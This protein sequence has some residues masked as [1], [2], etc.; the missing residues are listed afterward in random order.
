MSTALRQSDAE[1][2]RERD[3]DDERGKD[4]EREG[5]QEPWPPPARA[6]RRARTAAAL[7][8]LISE[9]LA[10]AASTVPRPSTRVRLAPERYARQSN[11]GG[12][13]EGTGRRGRRRAGVLFSPPRERV[14]VASIAVRPARPRVE[15][16][17]IVPFLAVPFGERDRGRLS[18]ERVCGVWAGGARRL[19]RRVRRQVRV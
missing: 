14:A 18:E 5:S 12:R 11:R 15:Q 1:A 9:F 8:R 13:R 17:D 3:R 7:E 6:C 4:P 19:G 16:L 2:D 10:R